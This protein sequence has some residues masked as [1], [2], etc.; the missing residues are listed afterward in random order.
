MEPPQP[1]TLGLIVLSGAVIAWYAAARSL[2]DA[3]SP[4]DRS[5]TRRALGYFIPIAITATWLSFRA[6]GEPAAG[7]AVATASG[8]ACLT[9]ACGATLLAGG[10]S[11]QGGEEARRWALLVPTALLLVLCG[12]SGRLD[13]FHALILLAQGVAVLLLWRGIGSPGENRARQG[14]MP[15]PAPPR[16]HLA[17]R[18]LIAALAICLAGLGAWGAGVVTDELRQNLRLSGGMLIASLMIAPAMVLPLVG[19]GVSLSGIGRGTS[20]VS[21]QVALVVLNVCVLLPL[22]IVIQAVR[23]AMEGGAVLS[24]SIFALPGPV[25]PMSIWRLDCVLLLV[26]A[27]FLLPVAVARWKWGRVE[28]L[29]LILGYGF[30]M[31]LTAALTRR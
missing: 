6:G 30:F 18:T 12:L 13:L 24:G 5:S 11:A 3:L 14:E 19:A 23:T 20:A 15:F 2:A 7:I 25:M 27:L 31:V 1:A 8:V 28:G 21:T 16:R 9:L 17:G 22:I 29:V 4:E 10:S 26:L